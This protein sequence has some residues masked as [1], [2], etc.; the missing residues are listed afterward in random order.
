MLQKCEMLKVK[1]QKKKIK[2]IIKKEQ[3]NGNNLPR[4]NI[5]KILMIF[6]KRFHLANSIVP[7][8]AAKFYCPSLRCSFLPFYIIAE[9]KKSRICKEKLLLKSMYKCLIK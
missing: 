8:W 5:L 4:S 7:L 3:Q 2:L 9:G 6:S 1:K